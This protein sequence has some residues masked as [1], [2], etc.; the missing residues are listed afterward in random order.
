M[1]SDAADTIRTHWG[2]GF[3]GGIELT[4]GDLH[5]KPLAKN[6]LSG[7]NSERHKEP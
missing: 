7:E 5:A 2:N 3:R 1:I 6:Y 4:P